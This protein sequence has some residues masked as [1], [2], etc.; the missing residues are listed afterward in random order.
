MALPDARRNLPVPRSEIDLFLSQPSEAV[1]DAL[2]NLEGDIVVL[3]AG[4]KMGLHLCLML[5]FALNELEQTNRVIAVSRFGNLKSKSE[6]EEH[7]V[8]TRAGDLRDDDFV[9][10]LPEAA[11]V[12]YLV[13]AKFGTAD[14]P[15]LLRE[16]NVDLAKRL[17]G[18][19]SASRIVAFSTGC[20]YSF[21]TPASGGSHEGSPTNPVGEYAQSCLERELCFQE[22]S[23]LHDTPVV[24]IRLNYSVEFRYGVLVDIASKVFAGEPV[25]VSTGFVNV[26]WQNDALCQIVQALA[27][28]QSPAIPLNITGPE[29][30]SVREIAEEFARKFGRTVRLEGEEGET[31][32]LNNASRSHR[33][34]GE[35]AVAINTMMDWVAVW[36]A[37]G[38]STYGKPTGFEKR[39]GKF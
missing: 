13:G 7:G 2:R 32:W 38:G 9:K 8:E 34:F 14:H 39:D 21:V 19:Y 15:D 37:G 20:V 22:V 16:T 1:C 3:G 5:R 23:A 24:L 10:S 17:A 25:D 18:R 30:L 33:L 29:I 6:Y 4:G 26:I 27:L 31:A 12:F 28:V 35:P 11:T 36:L